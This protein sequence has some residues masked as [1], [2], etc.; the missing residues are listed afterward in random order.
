MPTLFRGPR[1]R[2]K[3]KAVNISGGKGGSGGDG[4]VYGGHGG[5]GEGP[6]V[7]ISSA[8]ARTVTNFVTSKCAPTVRSDFRTI[9]LG[10]INLQQEIHSN[11]RSGVAS[12]RKLHSAKI[13]VDGERLDVTVALYQGEGAK[14]EWRQD[15]ARY[16]AIRHTN[17][18]QLYGTA[19]CDLIPL[20]QMLDLYA[21]APMSTVYIHVFIRIEFEVFNISDLISPGETNSYAGSLRIFLGNLSQL[22]GGLN[23]AVAM[24]AYQRLQS[25]YCCTFLSDHMAFKAFVFSSTCCMTA[26]GSSALRSKALFAC[27]AAGCWAVETGMTSRGGG[28]GGFCF[29]LISVIASF[30]LLSDS[31]P[32]A[33]L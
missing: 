20:Q 26:P 7:K 13:L 15:I 6:S 4:G 17:I 14:E 22:F 23:R 2:G 32:T 1:Q 3:G 28:P 33:V 29:V 11:R 25:K 21:H 18:V 27:P 19:S 30:D 9:P 12:L 31:W 10:E 24:L 16:R 8:T 5:R